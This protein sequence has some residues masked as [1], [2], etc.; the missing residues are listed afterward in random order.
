MWLCIVRMHDQP[1]FTSF[2]IPSNDLG[3]NISDTVSGREYLSFWHGI[4]SLESMEIPD[5]R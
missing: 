2:F 4:N 5:E 3:E 1:P